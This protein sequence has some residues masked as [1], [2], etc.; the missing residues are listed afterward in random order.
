MYYVNYFFIFAFIGN[1]IERFFYDSWDSGILYGPWTP[2][3]GWGVVSILLINLF[4]DKK[5]K[6]TKIPKLIALFLIGAVFLS[7]LEAIGGYSIEWI[8]GYSHWGYE[9]Y[10]FNIG[11]YIALEM[12]V[13]WGLA[14]VLVVTYIKPLF[15]KFVKKIPKLI[16]CILIILY[17]I[18]NFCTF[19]FRY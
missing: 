1:F 17:I 11:K 16:T 10:R 3:Y 2:I 19:L 4:I 5:L 15:D 14:S 6:L 9:H 13:V 7:I 8:F 12:A 18:D